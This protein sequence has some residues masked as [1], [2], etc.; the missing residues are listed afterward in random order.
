MSIFDRRRG[1]G[2]QPVQPNATG[3]REKTIFDTDGFG[4]LQ[5][6]APQPEQQP[7]ASQYPYAAAQD[8][9]GMGAQQSYGQNGVYGGYGATQNAQSGAYTATAQDYSGDASYMPRELPRV[10][11]S[12]EH[13]DIYIYEY[14]DRLE[15]YLKTK[16]RM[17]LFN[18]VKRK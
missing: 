13:E 15:Y 17:H 10:F 7:T 3:Y 12:R 16:T 14:S 11:A 5:Q 6:D 9:Y 4:A 18:T 2:S 8:G 1:F